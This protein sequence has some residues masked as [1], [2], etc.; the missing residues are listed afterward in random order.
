MFSPTLSQ[1]KSTICN[2]LTQLSREGQGPLFKDPS[3]GDGMTGKVGGAHG[4]GRAQQVCCQRAGYFI[5]CLDVKEETGKQREFRERVRPRGRHEKD[6]SEN[7]ATYCC[8]GRGRGRRV[9][10]SLCAKI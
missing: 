3:I 9:G 4:D 7:L 5:V 1:I 2:L 8:G 10:R 6:G